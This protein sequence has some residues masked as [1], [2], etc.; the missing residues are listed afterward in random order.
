VPR[1][2]REK[3]TQRLSELA[4]ASTFGG[5]QEVVWKGLRDFVSYH[6]EYSDAQ[7][8]LPPEEVD[9]LAVVA[10]GLA[11]SSPSHRHGWLF[12]EGMVTL[13]DIQRRD[14]FEEYEAAVAAR[15]ADAVADILSEEGIE[16]LLRFAAAC[17]VPGQVG[18]SLARN[19]SGLYELD[20]LPLLGSEERSEVDL[21]FGYF[22]QRFRVEGWPW[23][24]Q[25]LSS[26]K[27]RSLSRRR[28]GFSSGPLRPRGAGFRGRPAL[29][30]PQ[31]PVCS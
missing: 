14:D 21:A 24:D 19:S 28:T 13:G 11:P 5:T 6:R 22:G 15:R 10:D 26:I 17:A 27:E 9:R 18:A 1:D 29:N 25:F 20:L 4:V 7:W 8:A 16:S 12:D 3:A 23:L 30:R 2:A 31:A